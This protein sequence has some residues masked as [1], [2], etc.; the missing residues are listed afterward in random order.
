MYIYFYYSAKTFIDRPGSREGAAVRGGGP[1]RPSSAELRA[2][3]LKP[4]RSPRMESTRRTRRPSSLTAPRCRPSRTPSYDGFLSNFQHP[5]I[6][7][8]SKLFTIFCARSKAFRNEKTFSVFWFCMNYVEFRSL[9]KSRY[10]QSLADVRL[11]S[12]F[13]GRFL[14]QKG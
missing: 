7:L 9:E 13:I 12:F 14:E 5:Q 3:Q 8:L 10:R 11:F 1:A 2:P 6:S 4:W